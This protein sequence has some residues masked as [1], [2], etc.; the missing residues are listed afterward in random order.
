MHMYRYTYLMHILSII[1]KWM[2]N[3]GRYIYMLKCSNHILTLNQT[4]FRSF[5][6]KKSRNPVGKNSGLH[7]KMPKVSTDT[8][9]VFA[10]LLFMHLICI[11]YYLYIIPVH[12]AWTNT[13]AEVLLCPCVTWRNCGRKIHAKKYTVWTGRW[14]TDGW[15]NTSLM[16]KY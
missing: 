5:Q 12:L 14:D 11:I 2:I 13:P 9:T 3:S 15:K 8:R 4:D 16:R 1:N 7:H 6:W 10:Q